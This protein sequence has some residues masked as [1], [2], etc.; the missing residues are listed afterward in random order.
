MLG[1][2]SKIKDLAS[3]PQNSAISMSINASLPLSFNVLR[4]TGFNKYELRLG[5]KS[6]LTKSA[7]PLE[8]GAHY[9]GEASGIK[10]SIIIKNMLKKPLI[11]PVAEAG[12]E[13]A[14]GLVQNGAPWFLKAVQE[15]LI[16]AKN[17]SEF[18]VYSKMLLALSEGVASIGFVRN[19]RLGL[20]Q[21]SKHELYVIFD[22]LGPVKFKLQHELM[23]HSPFFS[24]V[25]LLKQNGVNAAQSESV[26]PLWQPK[27]GLMDGVA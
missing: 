25:S 17:V 18:G 12:I 7:K 8:I 1:A 10:D 5:R 3:S 15:G 6:L 4:K 2:L 19:D 9:W 20:L 23:A 24:V 22:E 27:N 16:K 21:L 13:L 14:E 26:R 11:T